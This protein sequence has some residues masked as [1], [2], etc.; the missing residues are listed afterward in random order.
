[1]SSDGGRNWNYVVLAVDNVAQTD[2]I[3]NCLTPFIMSTLEEVEF[4]LDSGTATEFIE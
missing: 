3:A 4:I 1:M 2:K